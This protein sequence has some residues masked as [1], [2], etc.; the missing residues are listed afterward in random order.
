MNQELEVLPAQQF[1]TMLRQAEVIA[2]ATNIPVAYRKKPNDI[3]AVALAGRAFEW[4]LM[5]SL[6]FFHV[7]EGT[8][9]I[10]P[11]GMLALVRQKGH[12]VTASVEVDE[13]GVRC[14]VASGKR[15]DT[16]DT[17]TV[18]FSEHD[19]KK[20]GLSGKK[21]WQQYPDRMVEWRAVSAL[22]RFLFPDVLL[23]A[24][25]TP[26]E[27]GA[28][29]D[30]TGSPLE[31]DPFVDPILTIAEAKRRVLQVFEGDRDVAKEWWER[32]IDP[33]AESVK[34]SELEAFFTKSDDDDIQDA[35]IVL[36]LFTADIE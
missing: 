26:E 30:V 24:G 17:H 31:P 8:A 16:G 1:D 10:K 4:D 14:G 34:E 18:R 29:V 19:A 2:Q 28:V 27:V 36:D 3:V 12:S 7:I 25:Y 22:C 21:N 32:C 11:E 13:S 6:R 35:E 9:S 15:A 5:T 33:D 23:G 20:A